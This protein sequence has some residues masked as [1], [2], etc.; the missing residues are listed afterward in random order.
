MPISDSDIA[1]TMRS[2]TR[3]FLFALRR[4][5]R[6]SLLPMWILEELSEGPAYGYSLLLRLKARHGDKVA[7]GPSTLY[8]VLARLRAAGLVNVFHGT[9]SQGPIRK[10]YELTDDGHA[11]LPMVRELRD[12]LQGSE[13]LM[14]LAAPAGR[15]TE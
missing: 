6:R 3:L 13:L 10:Y 7:V 5:L 1:G 9:F 8:P 2:G 4:D 12:G 14:R 11:F 15:G